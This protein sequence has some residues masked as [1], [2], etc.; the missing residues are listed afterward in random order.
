MRKIQKNHITSVGLAMLSTVMITGH[1]VSSQA[2]TVVGISAGF[3][4][5]T[6]VVTSSGGAKCWG[7]NEAGQLGNNDFAQSPVP[8]DVIGLAGGAAAISN[9]DEFSCALTTAGGVQCWGFNGNGQLGNPA[10]PDGS[11]VPI[12][13]IG[14]TSGVASISTG[15]AHACAVTVAGGVKCWGF[16]G[17]GQIGNGTTVDSPTPVDVV[18]LASG[19]SAVAAGFAHTCALTNSGGIKCWGMNGF[20][21]FGD[22]TNVDSYT[23]V[24]AGLTG[25]VAAIAVGSFH[26][27]GLSMGDVLEC[28]GLNQNGQVGGGST[29]QIE[30]TPTEVVLPHDHV[31]AVGTGARHTCALTPGPAKCWGSNDHSQLGDRSVTDRFA[32]V[33]VKGLGGNVRVIAGGEGHSCAITEEGGVKCWGWNIVGQLGDGTTIDSATPVKVIGLGDD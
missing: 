29:A 24:D 13:V 18:G 32:P 6:C 10:F 20:S 21:Q 19:I 1:S 14:L 17:N 11:P 4:N 3:G 9:G 26:T 28:W 22:G 12:D 7:A 2:S 25:N 27:C 30:F 23:A 31:L 5:H 16:N 8:V 33:T 15:E